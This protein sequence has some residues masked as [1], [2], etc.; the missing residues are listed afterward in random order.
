MNKSVK[1]IIALT[2][3]LGTVYTV[4][5]DVNIKFFTTKGYAA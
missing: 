3:V 4:A 2:L 1:R 5:P